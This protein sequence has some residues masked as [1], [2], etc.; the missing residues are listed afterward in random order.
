MLSAIWE[1]INITKQNIA[2]LKSKNFL[3]RLEMIKTD[4]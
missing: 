3:T 1:S 4:G 2:I